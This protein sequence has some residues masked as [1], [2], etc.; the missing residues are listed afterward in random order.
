MWTP[1]IGY[2]D[3]CDVTGYELDVPWKLSELFFSEIPV[4][5]ILWS[6]LLSVLKT[7]VRLIEL[8]VSKRFHCSSH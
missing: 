7:I 2:G 8:S 6:R 5:C 1:K 4:T 3:V